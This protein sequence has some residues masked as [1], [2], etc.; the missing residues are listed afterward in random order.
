MECKQH[1]GHEKDEHYDRLPVPVG[2]MN[3][4]D[5]QYPRGK[6]GAGIQKLPVY[7]FLYVDKHDRQRKKRAYQQPHRPGEEIHRKKRRFHPEK[8]KNKNILK[9][10]DKISPAQKIPNSTFCRHCIPP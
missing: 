7:P 3:K 9:R 8:H 1:S 6:R 4:S 5:S 2:N 10:R